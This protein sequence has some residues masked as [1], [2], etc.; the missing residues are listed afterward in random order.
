M[1]NGVSVHIEYHVKSTDVYRY[2]SLMESV[3]DLLTE[4]GARRIQWFVSSRANNVYVERF[5]LPTESHY[6][7]LKRLRISNEHGTFNELHQCLDGGIRNISFWALK[8]CS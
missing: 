2:E 6:Y 7:A 4:F 1:N 5:E 3:L 8:K